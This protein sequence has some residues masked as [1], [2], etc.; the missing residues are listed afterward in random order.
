[1]SRHRRPPPKRDSVIKL[2][3]AITHLA[4]SRSGAT[5]PALG[6]VLALL[7]AGCLVLATMSLASAF[8]GNPLPPLFAVCLWL[9][10]ALGLWRRH[11]LARRVALV[12]LW[13]VIVIL[14]IGVIN[15]FAAMDG[16][17]PADTPTWR[18]AAPVYALVALALVMAHVLG[19]H[20]AE[21]DRDGRRE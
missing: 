21:F 14:P 20:K 8:A 9:P 7:I 19:K 16:L 4:K 10:L 18:L 13:L 6:I 3:S 17:I 5:I 2:A 1:M 11:A 12:L 15:P